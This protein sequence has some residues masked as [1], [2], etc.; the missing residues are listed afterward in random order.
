MGALARRR[1]RSILDWPT[2][3]SPW[4]GAF[5][6]LR[7]PDLSEIESAIDRD[8]MRIEEH[9]ENGELVVKAEMPGIDPDKDVEITVTDSTLRVTAERREETREEE[10]EGGYRSEFRYGRFTRTVPLP[11]GAT[12]DDVKASYT[13]GILEIRIPVAPERAEGRKIP[14]SRT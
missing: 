12:Q 13:D 3:T 11:A 7:L 8:G 4:F 10:E 2:F 14:I 5:P 1:G 9:R 6:E